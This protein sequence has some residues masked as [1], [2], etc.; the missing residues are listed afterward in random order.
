MQTVTML[1][2]GRHG[3]D[4]QVVWQRRSTAN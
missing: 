3:S 1:S 4:R 2:N